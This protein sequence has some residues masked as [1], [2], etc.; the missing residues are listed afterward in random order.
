MRIFKATYK[1]RSCRTRRSQKW[2]VEFRDHLQIVRRMP[3]FTD[4]KATETLARML[5]RLLCLRAANDPPDREIT[6]WLEACPARMKETF[7]RWGLIDSHRIVAGKPLAK[8]VDDYKACLLAKNNTSKHA[9]MTVRHIQKLFDGCD[10]RLWSEISASRLQ[11]YLADLRNDGNGISA[12][13]FNSYLQSC[14]GFCEWMCRDGR[15]SENPIAHLSRLNT[16]IDRRH[17]RRGLEPHEIRRLLQTTR[18]EPKRFKMTGPERAMLYQLAMETGLRANELRTLQVR[19]F[20]LDGCTV[21]V[22]AAYS[23]HRRRD[24]LPLRPDTAEALRGFLAGKKPTDR[25]F[26]VPGKTANMLRADLA[27]AGIA[28]RDDAGRV[29]DF[30]AL[31][32]T[33]GSLLAAAGVYPKV[34]QSL[35]RH[36]SVELTLGRYSHVFR[37]QESEAVGKLPDFSQPDRQSQKAAATGTEGAEPA[38]SRL[39]FCLASKGGKRRTSANCD[40]HTDRGQAGFTDAS[41]H[42][43]DSKKPRSLGQEHGLQMNEADATRTR[44]LRIDSPML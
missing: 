29:V 5:E 8:H 25:A 28:Y 36:S 1:D 42:A 4:R 32:H 21:I 34:A 24:T 10:F 14:K 11:K 44:N 9:N 2:Y 13:T 3:G 18:S 16:R 23:K 7:V 27:A 35:M 26:T 12:R 37:G 40:G 22:E 33:T 41:K 39:A 38:D 43:I 15:A 20:D 31:R 19:S 17:D 6:A 30:H